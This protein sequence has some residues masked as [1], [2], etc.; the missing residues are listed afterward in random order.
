LSF[1]ANELH[2]VTCTPAHILITSLL[3]ALYAYVLFDSKPRNFYLYM[4]GLHGILISTILYVLV[5]DL[6]YQ[7]MKADPSKHPL[8][9]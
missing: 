1:M 8:L 9:V 2:A 6:L 4:T 5:E 7:K 3:N